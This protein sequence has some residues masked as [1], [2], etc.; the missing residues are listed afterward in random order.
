MPIILI[1]I[2]GSLTSCFMF[3]M[4]WT[5]EEAGLTGTWTYTNDAIQETVTV[6]L[7]ETSIEMI[8]DEVNPYGYAMTGFYATDAYYNDWGYKGGLSV[9][10]DNLQM[11]ITITDLYR[12][13]SAFSWTNTDS[14]I[15]RYGG[16]YF[17]NSA[18]WPWYSPVH[19]YNYWYTNFLYNN[20]GG[21][22]GAIGNSITC[23][24]YLDGDTLTLTFDPGGLN[25]TYV[26]QRN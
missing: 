23:S 22:L 24:Y 15:W 8:F 12:F 16:G 26:F 25:Q 7:T 11:D 2:I 18:G 6:T 14:G 1:M 4:D 9:D 10:A 21:N 5:G 13:Y 3:F 19:E 20:P 17:N